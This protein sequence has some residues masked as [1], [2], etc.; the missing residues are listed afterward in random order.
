[1]RRDNGVLDA[2]VLKSHFNSFPARLNELG[3]E[4]VTMLEVS[5]FE[6]YLRAW[7][8]LERGAEDP[9]KG[10]VR[11]RNRLLVVGVD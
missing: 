2:D 4:E 7:E 11:L 3:K 1:V 6:Q 5:V 10:G 8:R 9:N